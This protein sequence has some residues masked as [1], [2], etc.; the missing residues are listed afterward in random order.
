MERRR[1]QEHAAEYVLHDPCLTAAAR[2][3]MR[4]HMGACSKCR[5]V[6]AET[7]WTIALI[8]DNK[9]RVRGLICSGR[10]GELPNSP[11][12]LG[13]ERKS[14]SLVAMEPVPE[15]PETVE[16]SWQRLKAR[17]EAMDEEK[18]RR[19][20]QTEQRRSLTNHERR[21]RKDL[22]G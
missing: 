10:N 2:E 17:F 19:V 3:E 14:E 12:E 13:K 11:R 22:H 16:A 18:R 15:P 8:R 21:D 20:E 5:Q 9:E 4:R 6:Y 7:Q 1:F